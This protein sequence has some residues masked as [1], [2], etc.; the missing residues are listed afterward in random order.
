MR[1]PN[2]E[3][4]AQETGENHRLPSCNWHGV[5][6]FY[7]GLHQSDGACLL[8]LGD[9][10]PLEPSRQLAKCD[11]QGLYLAVKLSDPE[12]HRGDAP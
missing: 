1:A 3:E 2:S 11:F 4:K 9:A 8:L 5:L 10:G 6:R 12:S 7:R